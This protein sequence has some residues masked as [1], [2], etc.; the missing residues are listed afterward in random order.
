MTTT[1]EYNLC[2]FS[3]NPVIDFFTLKANSTKNNT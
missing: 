1:V 2:M 3:N